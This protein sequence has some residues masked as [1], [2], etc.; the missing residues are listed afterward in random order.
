MRE[1]ICLHIGQA[2]IQ[3]GNACWE[4]FSLEHGIKPNG[5]TSD[6]DE[7]RDDI[8][9]STTVGDESFGTFFR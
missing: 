9:V 2:G 7:Y 4:L 1:I 8:S 3:T 6:K 5:R